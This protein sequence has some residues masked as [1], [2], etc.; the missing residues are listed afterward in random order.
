MPVAV[1]GSSSQEFVLPK[2]WLVLKLTNFCCLML[3]KIPRICIQ[4][5]HHHQ[6][7][8]SSS[9][10]ERPSLVTTRKS[11]MH[12]GG[13]LHRQQSLT[14]ACDVLQIR[15]LPWRSK[16]RA[17]VEIDT[18]LDCWGSEAHCSKQVPAEGTMDRNRPDDL[19]G[20]VNDTTRMRRH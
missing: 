15:N 6:S 10:S 11:H 2:F 16:R 3:P 9:S 4:A 18:T 12:K 13:L 20:V 8:S 7:S 1:V 14:W 19:V 17:A 5:P